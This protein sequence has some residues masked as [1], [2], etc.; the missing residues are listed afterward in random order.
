L[1]AARGSS[2]LATGITCQLNVAILSKQRNE[3][4]PKK[5]RRP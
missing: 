1:P 3:R 2:L 5:H 4:K